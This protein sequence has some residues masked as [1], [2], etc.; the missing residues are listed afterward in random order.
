MAT[1]P[2]TGDGG[3]IYHPDASGVQTGDSTITTVGTAVT[4]AATTFQTLMPNFATTQPSFIIASLPDGSVEARLVTAQASETACTIGSAFTADLPA[5]T[6]WTFTEGDLIPK[7]MGITGPGR[8]TNIA[9][10]FIIAII[11]APG[12]NSRLSL[13]GSCKPKSAVCIWAADFHGQYQI[14][15]SVS[16]I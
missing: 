10:G 8:T 1:E 11:G 13:R 4:G 3:G 9:S 14:V 12:A 16:S 2:I 15:D 5:L 6:T 7:V